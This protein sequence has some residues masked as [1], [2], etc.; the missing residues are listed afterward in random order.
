MFFILI[1]LYSTRGLIGYI[2]KPTAGHRNWESLDLVSPW[3]GDKFGII[4]C[5]GRLF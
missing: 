2:V 1:K 3:M 5:F 4:N